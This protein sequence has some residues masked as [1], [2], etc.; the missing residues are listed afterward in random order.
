MNKITL[1][2]SLAPSDHK[3]AIY[4][5]EHQINVFGNQVDEILLT[6][7]T[8]KSKGRFAT[9]WE[10][11]N[12]KMWD[13]LVDFAKKNT[14]I[15]LC[16]IDYSTEKNREIAKK[17]FNRNS[18]P[19]KDWRGGPFYTYFFGL[20][21]AK[22]DYVFHIDSDMFFGG[23]SQTWMQEAI[24]LYKSDLSIL[25]INPLAGPPKADATLIGQKYNS[26]QSKP[27]FFMFNSMSTRLFLVAKSRLLKN[28]IEKI[29]AT[30]WKE[31]LRALYKNNPPFKLPEEILSYYLQNNKLIR[32]DFMGTG[33]GL[34]SLHPPYRTA[35]FYLDLPQII[36]KIET[37]NIPNS[38]RGNYDIIDELVDWT[39]ARNKLAK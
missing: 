4:L 2:I 17:Y 1:Q 3:H 16:K 21:E 28:P 10:E 8:H 32:I 18:I 19:A 36:S 33:N 9:N 5:L 34:W 20:N 35:Q 12:L 6:Y 15:N 31:L 30:K 24:N 23:M 29:G 22:H 26:Y 27:Y 7:D 25:F 38:Q 39:E 11:N 13:F 37:G 14:K